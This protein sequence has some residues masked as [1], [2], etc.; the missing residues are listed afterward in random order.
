MRKAILGFA[1]VAP[2]LMLAAWPVSPIGAIGIL[3]A[4]HML[5]LYPTLRARSQWLGPV[6]T[7]FKPEGDQVW[8]TIDDGPTDDTE[9][10]VDVLARNDAKATFYVKGK[11]AH[12]HP[13]R[14]SRI[15]DAAHD[16]GNHSLSHPSAF[17][18]CLPPGAVISEIAGCNSVISEI[19]GSPPRTFR[20]PVGMKNPFVHP[21]LRQLGMPL[22]A[23]T[24]RGFDGVDGFDP[25]PTA[26]RI[27][28]EVRPGAIIL[29]HQ[30]VL[31]TD[32]E[33]ASARCLQLVLE[34]LTARGLR[35]VIPSTDSL[36]TDSET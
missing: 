24:S 27:L 17:F 12:E 3:F 21:V 28:D 35:C 5:I 32:G 20:A 9:E 19:A 8:L 18:W 6:I 10:V 36:L 29:M 11:L 25:E 26:R 22:V 4:S 1:F 7:H 16:L 34:G 31:G 2:F 23:W 13:E 30:G 14:L 15:I 33:P